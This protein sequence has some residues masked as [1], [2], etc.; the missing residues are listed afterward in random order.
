S[1][2]A[3]WSIIRSL[4]AHVGSKFPIVGNGDVKTVADAHRMLE[5]TGCDY[6]MIGRG[7]LGNPWIFRQLNGGSG[8]TPEEPREAVLGHSRAPVA[9]V[10]RDFNP[11]GRDDYTPERL[12]QH[13]ESAAV[14]SFRK[15]LGWYAHGLS[16]A[17][18]FRAG[19][20]ALETAAD[21]LAACERFFLH[22]D[23]DL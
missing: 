8:P 1:G 6:V 18:A 19:V 4:K 16:G 12:K 5:T 11:R 3:D 10:A 22:A 2:T 21:V 7:A 13:A 17:S 15:H 14:H 20:N 23:V 9:F